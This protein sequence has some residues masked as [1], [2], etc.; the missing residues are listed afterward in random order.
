MVDPLALARLPQVVERLGTLSSNE[1]EIVERVLAQLEINR[2]A[3][4]LNELTDDLEA[5][6]VLE[7]LPGI[8]AEVRSR[9]QT[10]PP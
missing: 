2:T 8:I 1:L 3:A 10:P 7:R 4:E 9:H 6:G 5:R